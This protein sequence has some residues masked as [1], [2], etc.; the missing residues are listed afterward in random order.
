VLKLASIGNAIDN[1][2]NKKMGL[3]LISFA[4]R[5]SVSATAG[6]MG[7]SYWRFDLDQRVN[8]AV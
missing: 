7:T 1:T 2:K 8:L 6:L 5:S 3:H 4:C